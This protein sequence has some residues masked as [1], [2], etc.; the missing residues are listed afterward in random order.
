MAASTFRI[1]WNLQRRSWPIQDGL[2]E[3]A[4][5]A[6]TPCL[7][8]H[9]AQHLELIGEAATHVPD[10]VR[11]GASDDIPW[12]SDHWRSE[13]DLRLHSYLG[14]SDDDVIWDIDSSRMQS[15]TLLPK[16]RS[17]LET[18]RCNDAGS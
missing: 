15:Q 3:D 9:V 16:L 10:K 17:L 8:C 4:F 2:D 1:C 6:D 11:L 5:V 7:R 14:I 12:R 13:T 18:A